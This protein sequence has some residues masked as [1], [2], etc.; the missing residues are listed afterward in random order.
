MHNIVT[1]PYEP[2]S[3]NNWGKEIDSNFFLSKAALLKAHELN[4]DKNSI[5]GDA[6]FVDAKAGNYRLKTGSLAFKMGF[7]NFDENFGVTLPALKKIA[8]KPVIKP[9]CTALN[10]EKGRR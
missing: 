4:L 5:A 6:L 2:I 10:K 1:T 7:K 8:D 9:L 3:M